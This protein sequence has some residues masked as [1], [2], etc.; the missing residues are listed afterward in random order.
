[1]EKK[2]TRKKK[3]KEETTRADR[4]YVLGFRGKLK[5]IPLPSHL[6]RN[7]RTSDWN[8]LWTF[9]RLVN[10]TAYFHFAGGERSRFC[11]WQCVYSCILNISP[12]VRA[13]RIQPRLMEKRKKKK[14][15]KKRKKLL[16]ERALFNRP[17]YSF[18]FLFLQLTFDTERERF[19][20]GKW[21][22]AA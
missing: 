2:E 1:M 3:G 19:N 10:F 18:F 11:V 17:D 13:A 5:N 16:C 6:P 12:A 22:P 15:G 7:F 14:K 8:F 21:Y 9:T 20:G 4:N